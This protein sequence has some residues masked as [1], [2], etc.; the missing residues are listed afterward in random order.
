L[1]ESHPQPLPCKEGGKPLFPRVWL[2]K[3]EA[4][5]SF[6]GLKSAVKREVDKRTN[7]GEKE[8][9]IDNKIEISY[10][11]QEAVIEV[12]AYKLVQVALQN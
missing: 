5:F 12:L 10:E 2:I 3:K 11:F 8:L 4:D 1:S 9:T 7:R 6:S